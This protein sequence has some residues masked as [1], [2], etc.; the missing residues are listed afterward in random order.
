MVN[1][2]GGIMESIL[3][4]IFVLGLIVFIHE[5]G[6]L[7]S[8]KTFGVYCKEFALGMGPKI[9]SIK[10]KETEY[11]IRLLPLGGFVSMVGEEG[12]EVDVPKERSLKGIHP[13]K[14]LVVMLAGIVM[15][16]ILAFVI[17]TGI[18]I[19]NGYVV[20][21]PEPV[22]GEIVENSSADV[23]GLQINDRIIEVQLSDGSSIQ[24]NDFYDLV[25]VLQ[26]YQNTMTFVVERE[27]VLMEIEV[28]PTLDEE[29]GVFVIGVMS[30][31]AQVKEI[32]FLEAFKYGSQDLVDMSASML[33]TLSR[34]VRGIGLSAISGPVG[35][36]QVTAQSAQMGMLSLLYL[37]GLL[38]LN[39]ALFNLIP[40]PLLDGG[41]AVL[42][43]IEILI[44]KPVNAKIEQ[45]LML[46]S[47]ILLLLLTLFV[48]SQDLF[49]LF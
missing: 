49:K 8:A 37:T 6:H 12:V 45:A 19:Y 11:S 48:T 2:F 4:F 26:L 9:Y 23:A 20:L 3:A 13:L 28:T 36:F 46:A 44:G 21:N 10:G 34:L 38:S 1:T 27:G 22:L 14:R 41:R 35:I 24:P 42:I 47:M 31:Q 18:N 17:M 15:N 33:M 32:T 39:V 30:P 43:F 29:R 40:L 16:V 7:L 25:E 5:L